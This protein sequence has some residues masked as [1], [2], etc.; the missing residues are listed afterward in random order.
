[1]PVVP[2]DD[3][4]GLPQALDEPRGHDDLGPATVEEGRCPVKPFARKEDVAAV[5]LSEGAP[6]EVAD[7]ES[8]VVTAD[9][10]EKRQQH[11]EAN[12][13]ASGRLR[14]RPRG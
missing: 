3:A 1:M 14:R 12:V 11:D 5:A 7:G 13:E 9:G 2:R 6:A 10:A 8:D 4:V